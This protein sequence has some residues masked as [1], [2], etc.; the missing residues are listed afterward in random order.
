MQY[1]LDG[2]HHFKIARLTSYLSVAPYPGRQLGAVI[3]RGNKVL[4]IGCNSYCKTHTLQNGI[5][6][7]LHAEISALIKRRHYDDIDSCAITIYREVHGQPAL[8]RPCKQCMALLQQFG[9]KRIYYSIAKMPH[10][11]M[12]KL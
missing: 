1:P 9:I 7:Y 5:K 4:S 12:I 3:S 10:Y 11:A 2:I 6:P 8:A